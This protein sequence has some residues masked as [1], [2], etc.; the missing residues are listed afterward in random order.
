MHGD[1]VRRLIERRKQ[2]NNFVL[3]LLSEKV[4]APSTVFATAPRKQGPF[5]IRFSFLQV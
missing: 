1:P 2:P 5:H 3:V 4:K